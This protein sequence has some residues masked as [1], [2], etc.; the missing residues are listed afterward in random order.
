MRNI[1]RSAEKTLF[2]SAR[3]SEEF[4]PKDGQTLENGMSA[5]R[6]SL[7]PLYLMPLR[8][9]K[10]HVKLTRKH[11]PILARPL[12]FYGGPVLPP[13]KKKREMPDNRQVAFPPT[14]EN[15]VFSEASVPEAV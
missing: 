1:F 5:C 14:H 12:F 15:R 8:C 7:F 3:R 6:H 11:R 13:D 10:R 4:R 9:Q 2:L